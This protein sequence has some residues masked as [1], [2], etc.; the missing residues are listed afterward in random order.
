M[1]AESIYGM[2][3]RIRHEPWPVTVVIAA[4]SMD[5][6]G[7]LRKAVASVLGQTAPPAQTVLVIDH[8]PD[9]LS[10]AATAFPDLTVIPNARNQGASGARNTGVA[11][12]S[13]ELVAFLDDDAV[14][15]PAWLERLLPHF[16][17]PEVVG[18]GGRLNPLWFTSRPRWFP[19]EFDWAVGASYRGMPEVAEPVRNVWS[20]N[21]ILR[22]R[23][24][25]AIGGFNED[26]G[27]VGK[28]SRPE[29]TDLCLRAAAAQAGGT[30]IYEPAG[31][32]GHQV[33]AN[34]ETL[35]FFV[36]RCF[37]EGRGKADL[38]ELNGSGAATASERHYTRQV[39]PRGI[40]RGLRE[41]SRGDLS[42]G[43]RT[44]AVA[45]GLSLAVAGFVTARLARITRAP[46]MPAED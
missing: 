3:T 45:A 8:N 37:N 7:A 24:F 44:L 33:P 19:P 26:F 46:G 12:S 30:W 10:R 20:G 1:P 21:M 42:G 40:A 39:L 25:E 43:A 22:R 6:W 34:R 38:A 9:L 18:V 17:M 27:K 5:R 16:A 29:D 23:V 11:A 13:G 15:E 41:A 32:A 14:A 4:Y 28:V 35:R 36:R 31:A 2:T